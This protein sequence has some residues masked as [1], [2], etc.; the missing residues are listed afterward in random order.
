[1]EMCAFVVD[2]KIAVVGDKVVGVY[3]EVV[4]LGGE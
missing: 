1:M 3:G 4:V 2:D